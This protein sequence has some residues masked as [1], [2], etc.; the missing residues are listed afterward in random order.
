[1][2]FGESVFPAGFNQKTAKDDL[3]VKGN[4]VIPQH[5]HCGKTLEDSRRLSTEVEPKPLRGRA[6]RSHMQVERS[7]GPAVSL[8]VAMSVLH[9]L[10]DH[11]YAIHLSRF[12][13]RVQDASR[14]LYIPA[15]TPSPGHHEAFDPESLRAR[16]PNLYIS[17]R[18]RA[19]NQE[20]ISPQ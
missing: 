20:K 9:S 1:M 7:M 2:S 15:C 17:T 8:R 5:N 12:D 13:P 3:F 18:I 4:R 6:G 11:I 19:S 10:K 14:P 16:N